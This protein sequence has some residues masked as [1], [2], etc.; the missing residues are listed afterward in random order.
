MM[1]KK[2]A[3]TLELLKILDVVNPGSFLLQYYIIIGK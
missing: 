2:E 3:L 1:D